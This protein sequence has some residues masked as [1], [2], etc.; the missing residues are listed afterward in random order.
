MATEKPARRYSTRIT[1]CDS[2]STPSTPTPA[3]SVKKS[4]SARTPKAHDSA[5]SAPDKTD[6]DDTKTKRIKAAGRVAAVEDNEFAQ[7]ALSRVLQPDLLETPAKPPTGSSASTKRKGKDKKGEYYLA[8]AYP[9]ITY[10][11]LPASQVSP[12]ANVQDMEVGGGGSLD[13]QTAP[14]MDMSQPHIQ[15]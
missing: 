1:E 4:A 11:N 12:S 7:Q 13:S 9:P 8:H 6:K 15:S 10:R 5:S 2:A 14:V 3:T